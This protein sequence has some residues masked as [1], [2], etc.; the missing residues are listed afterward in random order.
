MTV[1]ELTE[2][3]GNLTGTSSQELVKMMTNE[4]GKTLK[5]KEEIADSL[6]QIFSKKFRDIGDSQLGRGKRESLTALERDLKTEFGL[7]SHLQGKELVRAIVEAKTEAALEEA[8]AA[9]LKIGNRKPEE[10]TADEIKGLPAVKNLLQNAVTKVTE[11]LTQR[12]KEFQDYKN[13]VEKVQLQNLVRRSIEQI[14]VKNKFNLSP[15]AAQREKQVNLFI[16]TLDLSELK[17]NG[18]EIEL[19]DKEGNLRRDD[20]HNIVTFE[21]HVS[22]LNPFGVHQ[23]DPNKAGGGAGDGNGKAGQNGAG[24]ENK[25]PKFKTEEEAMI[26]VNR[27][28]KTLNKDEIEQIYKNVETGQD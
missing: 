23:F 28:L 5:T 27:N 6:N 2:V 26:Y 9:G 10:L 1:L 21:K 17:Q 12:E 25:M 22:D 16:K 8:K 3:L 19:V 4:D 14:A 13:G 20:K 7:D 24:G 15:D 18:E 11:Q